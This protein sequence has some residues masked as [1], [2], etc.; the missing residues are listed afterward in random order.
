MKGRVIRFL[1]ALCLFEAATMG[2]VISL[3]W[4]LDLWSAAR[5]QRLYYAERFE[6]EVCERKHDQLVKQIRKEGLWARLGMSG[7]PWLHAKKESM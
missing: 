6:G 3:A 1:V 4:T 7:Q 2:L 5:W